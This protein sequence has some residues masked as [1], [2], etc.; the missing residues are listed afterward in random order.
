MT[1]AHPTPS[2]AQHRQYAGL[3]SRLLALIVDAVLLTV[4]ATAVGL[5][6]PGLWA[7]V[8]G[9]SPGWLEAV[10]GTAAAVLPFLYFSVSWAASGSTAGELLFG[11]AVRRTDGSRVSVARAA[12]RAFLGL[13]FAPVWLVGMLLTLSDPLRRAL[14]D[15]L[16]GTVTRRVP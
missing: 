1:T 12:V 3:V 15:V 7:A 4:A 16:M 10:A 9:D 14:H 2:S 8:T 6:V 5:G 13:L 11:F